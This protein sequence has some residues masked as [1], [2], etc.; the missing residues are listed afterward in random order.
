M[1]QAMTEEIQEIVP[2]LADHSKTYE[3]PVSRLTPGLV[4]PSGT[5]VALVRTRAKDGTEDGIYIRDETG[6]LYK[7]TTGQLAAAQKM[8][9]AYLQP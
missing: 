6:E 1:M 2:N 5:P 4:T 7:F 3:E 9:Q 8:I